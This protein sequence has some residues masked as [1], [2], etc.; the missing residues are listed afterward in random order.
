MVELSLIKPIFAAKKPTYI[1]NNPDNWLNNLRLTFDEFLLYKELPVEKRYTNSKVSEA[2]SVQD[3]SKS[4]QAKSSKSNAQSHTIYI[5]KNDALYNYFKPPSYVLHRDLHINY[6]MQ[7]SVPTYLK[8]RNRM[9]VGFNKYYQSPPQTTYGGTSEWL[10]VISG[11]LKVDIY[12]PTKLN[13]LR[14]S[15]WESQQD[16][17]PTPVVEEFKL[18]KNHCLVIPGGWIT[19]RR[20]LADTFVLTG[21]FIN[22]DD[23]KNQLEMFQRDVENTANTYSIT[24]DSNI[25]S[26]YWIFLTS[27]LQS[28]GKDGMI[29]SVD[30]DACESLK[31]NIVEWQ[32]LSTN[33]KHPELYVPYG[34]KADLLVRDLKNYANRNSKPKLSSKPTKRKPRKI[35]TKISLPRRLNSS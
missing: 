24:R 14:V 27:L 12:K 6:W 16:P 33:G 5:F 8:Q 4:M 13:L 17:V 35:T 1:D 22:V 30:V 9:F 3:A 23:I 11:T 2:S 15:E 19:R 32:K 20:A 34:I 10:Y 18:R 31:R 28:E 25:R 29:N 7:E 26:L 21:E